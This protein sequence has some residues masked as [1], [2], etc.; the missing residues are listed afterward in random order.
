M[1]T[2]EKTQLD[3]QRD[4]IDALVAALNNLGEADL[5]LWMDQRVG[6]QWN[7]RTSDGEWVAR[8]ERSS[9]ATT[10]GTEWE[11]RR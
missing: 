7:V 11:V 2:E 1:E 3:A 6:L 10:R 9:G 5:R 8:V 4:A